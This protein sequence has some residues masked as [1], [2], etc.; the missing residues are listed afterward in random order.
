MTTE[1]IIHALQFCAP[2]NVNDK[3]CGVCPYKGYTCHA[4]LCND[5]ITLLMSTKASNERM[6]SDLLS[7][8]SAVDK[9]CSSCAS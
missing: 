4:D 3:R 5:V 1:G 9:L 6:S 8:R 7:L 2:T